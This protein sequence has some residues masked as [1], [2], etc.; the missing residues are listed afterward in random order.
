LRRLLEEAGAC[1]AVDSQGCT[2]LFTV[3]DAE[4]ARVLV[5]RG[6]RLDAA[7]H[8]GKTALFHAAECDRA[9]VV[10]ALLD[11]SASAAAVDADGRTA[12]HWA[13]GSEVPR[14]LLGASAPVDHL[15]K[16][17]QTALFFA[18]VRDDAAMVHAL[19]TAGASGAIRDINE[20][21]PLFYA[22]REASLPVVQRLVC[23]ALVD[24]AAKDVEGNTAVKKARERPKEGQDIVA[25]LE[26]VRRACAAQSAAAG[27]GRGRGGRGSR[28]GGDATPRR[29]RY[30]LVFSDPADPTGLSRVPFGGPEFEAAL[31]K[32]VE[33]RPEVFGDVWSEGLPLSQGPPELQEGAMP[34]AAGEVAAAAA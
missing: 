21:T 26:S 8:A 4:C 2:P 13:R 32:L 25:Y 33:A 22:A 7:D 27:R 12:L 18:A 30:C 10:R 9:G 14:L 19:S 34:V 6:L 29:K 16:I 20:Q 3:E 24:P 23:Q 11:C 15:D 31:A 17:K 28:D 5:E 1:D